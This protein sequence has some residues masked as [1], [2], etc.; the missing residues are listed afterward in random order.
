M[1]E[2]VN[3]RSEQTDPELIEK[4]Q[5]KNTILKICEP[6]CISLNKAKPENIASYMINWLQNKYNISS[7]LLKNDEKKELE[8]LKKDLENF[9]E[10]DE[11]LYF[12]ESQLKAKKET[13]VVEKKG[14]APP[15][16]KPRLPPG[17]FI[18]SDDED[19]NNQDDIDPRLDN[20]EYIES[21]ARTEF[22]PGTFEIFAQNSFDIKIKYSHKPP[23][24][25]E[26]IK[27]NLMKSPLFSELSLDIITKLINAMEE[28]NYS[29]MSEI[30]KQGDFSDMFYFILEGELECKM[31]F[32]IITRE[33]NK[34]KVENFA[35]RLVKVYYPGDYFGELNLLYH[36]PLRGTVKA[37]TEAKIYLLDRKIYKQILNKSFNEKKDNR[38][39]L[40][41]NVPIFETLTDE[42]FGI[43]TQITKEAI[44][45]KGDIIIKEN[46]FS[47]MLMIIE[48][49][50]CIGK[51]IDEKGKIPEKTRDYKE[52]QIFFEKS[53]LK[54]EQSDESL[55]AESNVV[56]LICID[57]YTFKNIFGPLEQ[58]LMRNMEIYTKYF[59]PL[60]EIVE[61]IKPNPPPIIFEGENINPN[62]MVPMNIINGNNEP[63]NNVDNKN[64]DELTQ[65]LNMEKE[66]LN[67]EYEK[68]LKAL[69]DEITSLQNQKINNNSINNIANINMNNINDINNNIINNNES[70]NNN[71]NINE[72]INK[73]IYNINNDINNNININNSNNN[74]NMNNIS[75]EDINSKIQENNIQKNS[76]N[77]DIN[78]NNIQESNI[79][80]S[81]N[82]ED[83]NNNNN[84]QESNIQNSKNKNIQ[85]SNIQNSNNN[86]DINTK[87]IHES[88]IQ[89]S[90]IQNSNNEDI[91][92]NKIQEID[93]GD[94]NNNNIQES[95]N[96]NS[97]NNELKNSTQSP[98]ILEDNNIKNSS[99]GKEYINSEN[100][101]KINNNSINNNQNN[102]SK[103]GESEIFEGKDDGFQ[104]I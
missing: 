101:Q 78:N 44:Y 51:K 5:L 53:L 24:I 69:N 54:E 97:N 55:I 29:A 60:P 22:R 26:F 57:R 37:I 95:N 61:E 100:D 34:K 65:K 12:L 56:R 76:N 47:N 58:I 8:K 13:K 62:N 36:T 83:I 40:Y 4:Q 92:N 73:D 86:E 2:T 59:P 43:L 35:P 71:N 39:L 87:K 64:I 32:T 88:N 67:E 38:I 19:T 25:F 77:E 81:N 103:I 16:P 18:P 63:F 93:N 89:E 79:Q 48:E 20:P 28:K 49:G 6:M 42:E 99:I 1:T 82:N 21:N 41:K 10:M 96:Q 52:E 17:D 70:V 31:G 74:N 50:K 45:Y 85:E 11:H 80:K 104:S 27:I 66:K 68:K 94:I 7:S 72:N 98:R 14:K 15:K 84:I 91:N 46:E 23:E 30:V 9:H 33:G 102:T 90:N 75:N 3:A